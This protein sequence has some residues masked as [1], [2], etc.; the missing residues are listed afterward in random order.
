MFSCSS[1]QES[2]FASQ[3][4]SSVCTKEWGDSWALGTF[5]CLR[6]SK[7]FFISFLSARTGFHQLFAKPGVL[8]VSGPIMD[9]YIRLETIMDCY[10]RLNNVGIGILSRYWAGIIEVCLVCLVFLFKESIDFFVILIKPALMFVR[11][12]SKGIHCWRV[13]DVSEDCSDL[14]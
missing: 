10:L 6:C 7:N 2:F 12:L 5:Y 9:C 8:H 13:F 11:Y 3:K 14:I 1:F 4:A